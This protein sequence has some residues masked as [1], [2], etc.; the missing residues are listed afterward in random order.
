MT[1]K[2]LPVPNDMT[3]LFWEAARREELA[4]QRCEEC[5]Y[6]NHPPRPAC[7]ACM[8]ESL[9]FVPVSGCGTIWSRT[10]LHAPNVPGWE[11]E[12]PFVNVAVELD[13]QPGLLMIT[14][15]LDATEAEVGR[16]VEVFFQRI[17]DEITLPQFRPRAR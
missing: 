14:N 6:F 12:I 1:D 3:A 10:V 8:S 5:G 7:D 15:W 17:N 4:I 11:D 2:A 9:A 13:E 16:P